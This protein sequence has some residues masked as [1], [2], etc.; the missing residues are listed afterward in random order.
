[1]TRYPDWLLR[2]EAYVEATR[3]A[4]FAY[5]RLDC[6]LW[7][8]GAVAAMTGTDLAAPAR[9]RYA[10][11]EEGTALLRADGVRS[12]IDLVARALPSVPPGRAG[13]GDVILLPGRTL[14]ILQG[15][16]AWAMG[17]GGL[18]LLPS[19]L[20]RRAWTV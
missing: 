3:R 17:E 14:G 19:E 5:G 20:A 7:A 8:A 9:G 11:L 10:T 1:M 2:L 12:H 18:G 4:P 13:V 15:R 16:L 6:A